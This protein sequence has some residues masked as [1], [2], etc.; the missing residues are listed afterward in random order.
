MLTNL[1]ESLFRAYRFDDL[2]TEETHYID[3]WSYVWAGLTGPFYVL[4]KGFFLSATLMALVTVGLGALAAFALLV[5]VN[6]ADS[7]LL[8][9]IACVALPV[10]AV[11]LQSEIAVR[12]VRAGY[13][14][15]GM[16]EGY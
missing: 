7:L 10:V 12:L 13:R 15:R 3:E 8:S 11:L 1:G 9:L 6:I 5:I 4:A 14:R 2:A 16:R